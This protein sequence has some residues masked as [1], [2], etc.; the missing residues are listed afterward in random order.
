VPT[1]L[2]ILREAL[3]GPYL[4]AKAFSLACGE[5]SP[6]PRLRQRERR[7]FERLAAQLARPYL[8]DPDAPQRTLAQRIMKRRHEL[9]VFVSNPQVPGDNNLAERSLRPAVIAR[10]ISGGARSAKGSQARMGLMSLFGTWAAQ[11]KLLL[12]SCQQVLLSPSPA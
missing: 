8:N 3:K 12:E 6:S 10:K 11:G 5:L 9:F 4:E 2:W 1:S 7:R